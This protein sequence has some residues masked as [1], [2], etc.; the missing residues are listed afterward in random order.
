MSNITLVTGLWNLG[1]D[2][3][4]EGWNRGFDSHYLSK[5]KDFLSIPENLIIFGD[6]ELKNF[7]DQHKTHDRVQFIERNLNWFE[8]NFYDKIQ[9]I[10]TNPSWYNQ[11]GWLSESTQARLE[12]YNPLVMQK[13]FLLNDAKIMDQFD[14]KYM[15][16]LDAGITNTVHSGYFTHDRVLEKIPKF[17]NKFSFV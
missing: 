14:S 7:V 13:V 10:R 12:M 5:F 3:L 16:W 9:E 8:G 11:K 17:I 1:R 15:F 6:S 2:T 4:S